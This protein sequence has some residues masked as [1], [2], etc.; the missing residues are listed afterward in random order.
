MNR[1]QKEFLC[2]VALV[3]YGIVAMGLMLVGG[4]TRDDQ[5]ANIGMGM[6]VGLF[7]A[8]GVAVYRRLGD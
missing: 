5:Q 7:V 1:L 2:S 6:A 4:C 8:A 3:I